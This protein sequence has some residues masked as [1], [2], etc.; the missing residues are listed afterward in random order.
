MLMIK[1][2]SL[3]FNIMNTFIVVIKDCSYMK[4]FFNKL[5]KYVINLISAIINCVIQSIPYIGIRT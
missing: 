3:F 5:L 2:Y 1:F 4:A